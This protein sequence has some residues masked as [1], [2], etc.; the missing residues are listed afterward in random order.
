MPSLAELPTTFKQPSTRHSLSFKDGNIAL[1]AK[2]QY[3]LVHQGILSRHSAILKSS[4]SDIISSPQTTTSEGIPVLDVQDSPDDLYHFLAALYD[5][6][7]ELKYDKDSFQVIASV[8]RLSTRYEVLHLRNQLLRG[9][10]EMWPDNLTEW[11]L[12]ESNATTES[13]VYEP[14]AVIPHPIPVINLARD[15][16]APQLLPSAFYDLS[17]YS[18]A[19]VAQGHVCAKTQELHRLSERD[20]L[21]LLKGREHASRFLS[22]FLVNYVEGRNPSPLCIFRRQQ[23]DISRRRACQAAFEGITFEILR[24]TNDVLSQRSSDPLF[25]LMDAVLMLVRV[26]DGRWL[27]PCEFCRADFET[28]VDNAR[29]EFWAL[30]PQW[31]AVDPGWT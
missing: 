7:S 21:A 24:D 13:G 1:L 5:G 31:F 20:L 3:F 19:R 22:T 17:R 18:P 23:F 10:T 11:D 8:L 26:E 6:L 9:L 28:V 30:L 27:R 14:R 16:N 15:V 29:D 25:A 4:I 2:G 12:R